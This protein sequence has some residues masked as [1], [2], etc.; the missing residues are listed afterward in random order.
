[1]RLRLR[2]R[3]LALLLPVALLTQSSCCTLAGMGIGSLIDGKDPGP[4][5]EALRRASHLYAGLAVE[6]TTRDGRTVAGRR[7]GNH[8]LTESE[9]RALYRDLAARS[10]GAPRLPLPG[11]TILVSTGGRNDWVRFERLTSRKPQ[12]GTVLLDSATVGAVVLDLPVTTV[13]RTIPWSSL[14]WI[15]WNDGTRLE[16]P[17]LL[18]PVLA[19]I[20]ADP[21]I[22]TVR[23][24]SG[25]REEF[26]SWEVERIDTFPANFATTIGVF[27]GLGF[28]V[29]ILYRIGQG[30]VMPLN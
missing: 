12:S 4:H 9:L 25:V 7:E 10:V 2:L 17:R 18:R 22:L 21:R 27:A 16:D 28:D 26:R 29:Y 14:E 15:Q 20:P 11:D 24:E 5:S 6:V 13:P 8:R 30:F 23:T 1:M 19:R 3:P